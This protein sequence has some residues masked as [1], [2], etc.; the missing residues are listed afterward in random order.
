M[1][2]MKRNLVN[3][4]S[5]YNTVRYEADYYT[6]PNLMSSNTVRDLTYPNFIIW[7]FGI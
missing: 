4:Y 2:R 5:F 3:N 7:L 1:K 6:L